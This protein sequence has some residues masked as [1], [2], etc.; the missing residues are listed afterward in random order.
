M[1]DR[2]YQHLDQLE[3]EENEGY[4]YEENER[5]NFK[6]EGR[7]MRLEKTKKEAISCKYCF[8]ITF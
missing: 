8:K 7:I 5:K 3:K 4:E 1:E 6:V 2:G